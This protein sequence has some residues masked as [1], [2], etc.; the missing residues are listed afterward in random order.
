MWKSLQRPW[1]YTLT[2]LAMNTQS[3][4]EVIFTLIW[5]AHAFQKL[6]YFAR[7]LISGLKLW[8]S[9]F[10]PCKP[11]WLSSHSCHNERVMFMYKTQEVKIK[12]IR[13]HVN[14][15]E[16]LTRSDGLGWLWLLVGDTFVTHSNCSF[17]LVGSFQCWVNL[18]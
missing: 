8:R 3:G 4:T 16:S 1:K 10:E 5:L 14:I 6:G 9:G 12:I 13:F 15:Y 7:N 17:H 18:G 11:C 2:R